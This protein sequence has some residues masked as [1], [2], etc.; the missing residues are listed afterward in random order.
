MRPAE[1]RPGAE[2]AVV[3][4]LL[5]SATAAVLFVVAYAL[6][7]ANPTQWLGLSLGASLLLLAAALVVTAKKLVVSE[8]LEE[9]YPPGREPEEERRLGQIVAESGSAITRRR[10]M[11]GACGAASAA[12]GS[13]LVVPAA[14]LGP[15]LGTDPFYTSPWRRGRR[16]VD[17]AGEPIPA[18]EVEVGSFY[19]AYPEDA[20]REQ[21]PA[22]LVLVR[23]EPGEVELPPERAGWAP[24]GI[25]AF[26]KICTHAGCAVSIYRHPKFEPTQPKPALVCPCHYSTFDPADGGSV[27][28][29]PA[30]RGLPQLPLLIDEAGD[31]RAAGDFSQAVGP[32]FWGVRGGRP[33]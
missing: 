7:W 32:S 3:A 29:G 2:L 4:L 1:P 8:E 24:E 13:A 26:S 15:V 5:A 21:L 19:T 22:P 16:L 27:T 20:E 12:L 11:A 18:G 28:F 23:L 10:L 33:A 31:L 30:G 14:S 17:S 6:D 25:L 9:E